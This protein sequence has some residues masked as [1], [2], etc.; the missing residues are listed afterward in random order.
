MPNFE[1]IFMAGFDAAM[2]GEEKVAAE[3]TPVLDKALANLGLLEEEEEG[4]EMPILKQAMENL[5]LL[6]EED[7]EEDVEMPVLEQALENLGLLDDEEEGEEKV[8]SSM[9]EA[10]AM[11]Y[12]HIVAEEREALEKEAGYAE[13]MQSV[14]RGLRRTQQK[15]GRF[16]ERLRGKRLAKREAVEARGR[17]IVER[18]IS[19]GHGEDP[20]YLPRLKKQMRRQT[21]TEKERA[22]TKSARR[23]AAGGALVLGAGALGIG[24]ASSK[25]KDKKKKK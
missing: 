25:K 19:K 18:D 16:I 21:R 2:D 13:M 14:K 15:G 9:L 20:G 23:K 6:E 8:A 4:V 7:G 22:K 5:G 12:G 24:A 10:L 1:E 11:E 3:E 17:K